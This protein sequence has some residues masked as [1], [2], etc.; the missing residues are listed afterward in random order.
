MVTGIWFVLNRTEWLEKIIEPKLM[1]PRGF[2][3]DPEIAGYCTLVLAWAIRE[4]REFK[5]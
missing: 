1:L 4:V 5:I 3:A 2:F